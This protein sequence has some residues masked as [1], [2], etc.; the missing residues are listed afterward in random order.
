MN[1]GGGDTQQSTQV[2]PPSYLSPY[3][4]PAVS[5]YYDLFSNPNQ[6]PQYFPGS[7]VAPQGTGTQAGIQQL[8]AAADRQETL[9]GDTTSGISQ[10]LRS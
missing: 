9:A 1:G 3:L 8:G 2:E 10:V 7:T 5:R 4:G 6:F